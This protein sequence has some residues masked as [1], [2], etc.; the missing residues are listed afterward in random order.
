[1]QEAL[2]AFYKMKKVYILRVLQ[3]AW[4]IIW[5]IWVYRGVEVIDRLAISSVLALSYFVKVDDEL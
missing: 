2:K 3:L 5:L 4:T 1:V